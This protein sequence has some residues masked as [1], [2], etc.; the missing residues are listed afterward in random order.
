MKKNV[1]SAPVVLLL[2]S[3]VIWGC[4]WWPFK[5]FASQGISSIPLI[6]VAYGLSGLCL[7]PWVIRQYPQWRTRQTQI[8]LIFIVGGYANLAFACSMIYGEVIRC[9]ALFYTIPIWGVLGGRLFLGEKIDFQRACAVSMAVVGAF[10]ILGGTK[11]FSAAPSWVDLLA[12]S[13][14]FAFAMNNLCFRATQS[15]PLRSKVSIM[16]LGCAGFASLLLISGVQVFPHVEIKAW[17]LP[18]TFGFVML[19]ATLATQWGVTKLEAGRASVIIVMELITSVIT[20][21]YFAGETM[22]PLEWFGG[23]MIL[24]AALLEAWR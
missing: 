11:I 5:V 15:V 14:G 10:F 6:M 19:G 20:A 9:M 23:A 13:A 3:S 17:L 24:S 12:I 7:F 21:T 2:C 4:T 8:G 1:L 18:I 16:F 22:A